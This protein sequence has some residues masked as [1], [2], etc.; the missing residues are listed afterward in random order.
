MKRFSYVLVLL[1]F[2]FRKLGSDLFKET[3]YIIGIQTFP[4][5]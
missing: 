3:D 4:T 1:R 2:T 5:M